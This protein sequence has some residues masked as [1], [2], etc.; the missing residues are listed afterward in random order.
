MALFRRVKPPFGLK[1]LVKDSNCVLIQDPSAIWGGADH[2]AR[3]NFLTYTEDFSNAAW[4]KFSAYSTITAT[5]TAAPVS[6]VAWK[7][8]ENDTG[9]RTFGNYQ[10]Q[11][12]TTGQVVTFT[13][14]FK[15]VE[16]QYVAVQGPAALTAVIDLS[17]GTLS[18]YYTG[19]PAAN[20][21]NT[22]ITDAGGGWYKVAITYA[23]NTATGTSVA[24]YTRAAGGNFSG[25]T[26][27]GVVGSGVLVAN[28][29]V[30]LASTLDQSHQKI[31]DWTTEQ[32][33]WAAQK[34]V[35]WLRR[36]RFIN[37][38]TLSTQT[39]SAVTANP[40]T[41][42]FTGTGTITFSTAYTGTLVGTGASDR[43]TA[44]FTPAAG[45]LVCTVT[46]TV[47]LA[48]CEAGSTATPYQEVG[49]SWAATYTALATDAGYP[50]SLYSDRAGTVA[51][52][53]PDDPVGKLLDLSGDNNHATA[54]SD[55]ARPNLRLDGNGKFYLERDPTDDNLPITWATVLSDSQLGPELVTNGTFTTDATGWTSVNVTPTIEVGKLKLVAT[56]TT[57]L[58]LA[59]TLSTVV[60]KTYCVTASINAPSTNSTLNAARVAVHAPANSYIESTI[61]DTWQ[62]KRFVFVASTTATELRLG[63][64]SWAAWGANGDIAYF[65]D[66]SVREVTGTNVQYIADQSATTETTGLILLGETSYTTPQRPTGDYGRIIFKAPTPN[67]A[68]VKKYLD[69][70]AG[71]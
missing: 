33:A 50:I 25:F 63:V 44:T 49:A 42:S 67:A 30:S 5:A 53:G 71:R 28:P 21:S 34:K 39:V 36:N 19:G 68:K 7:L 12:F 60:G 11:T 22:V 62:T 41:V 69:K 37:T 1:T 40:I 46:G 14:Y 54:P 13:A 56:S 29:M 65:D 35:P 24:F 2:L 52:Y 27:T 9:A 32:Y 47:T 64:A 58:Y 51:T 43:V 3:R 45:N 8:A 70:K 57:N 38:S 66:V 10:A 4:P 55:A 59:Q 20:S 23:W 31:T 26:H 17:N 18:G 61:E 48:Q 15:A 6:G 16:R